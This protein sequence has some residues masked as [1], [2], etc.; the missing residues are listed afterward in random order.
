MH[1]EAYR[2]AV[3]AAGPGGTPLVVMSHDE[4]LEFIAVDTGA[5]VLTAHTGARPDWAF[6]SDSSLL[7]YT[8][9]P[10]EKEN[11]VPIDVIEFTTGRAVRTLVSETEDVARLS[12]SRDGRWLLSESFFDRSVFLW[13]M[14]TGAKKYVFK[15]ADFALSPDGRSLAYW[16]NSPEFTVFDLMTETERT[17][18]GRGSLVFS[19]T[20]RYLATGHDGPIGIWETTDWQ[21]IQLLDKLRWVEVE[22]PKWFSPDE[23]LLLSSTTRKPVQLWEIAGGRE[24]LPDLWQDAAKW[25]ALCFSANSRWL[26]AEESDGSAGLWD[27]DSEKLAAS[28]FIFQGGQSWLVVTPAGYF[29][30][31]DGTAREAVMW[32]VGNG[33]YPNERFAK[34]FYRPGLLADILGGRPAKPRQ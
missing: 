21:R 11:Q 1:A 30:A 29:D 22:G 18:E 32:N 19:P 4:K 9:P 10:K 13:E 34:E 8:G 15:G 23:R 17:L 2:S 7:A 12:F 28:I 6:N 27:I 3:F 16:D 25:N 31:S 24:V 26:V 33:L 14:S 5:T 20:G